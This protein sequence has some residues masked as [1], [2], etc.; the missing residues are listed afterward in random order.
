MK[1]K[2]DSTT[3]VLLKSNL[4]GQV[5]YVKDRENL[6]LTSDQARCI[7]KKYEKD[8]IVNVETIKWQIEDERLDNEKITK[9]KK[10]THTKSN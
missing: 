1:G 2:N 9:K 5:M 10:K 4:G 3:F 8:S 6:C 7:Y